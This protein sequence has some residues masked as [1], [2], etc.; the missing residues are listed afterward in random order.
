MGDSLYY[1][2]YI[3]FF[4]LFNLQYNYI[5]TN[6]INYDNKKAKTYYELY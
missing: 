2:I 5:V 4:N 1:K 3:L 6:N